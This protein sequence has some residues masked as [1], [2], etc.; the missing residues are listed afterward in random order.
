MVLLLDIRQRRIV[1]FLPVFL[2]G[3]SLMCDALRVEHLADAINCSFRA[4]S[5]RDLFMARVR[6]A[7]VVDAI[8]RRGHSRDGARRTS[9]V[10]RRADA[11]FHESRSINAEAAKRSR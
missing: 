3:C 1:D 6:D 2:R 10:R 8:S 5:W 11:Q 4:T 7:E 9:G